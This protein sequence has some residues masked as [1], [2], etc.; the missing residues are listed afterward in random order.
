MFKLKPKTVLSH[1]VCVLIGEYTRKCTTRVN[2]TPLQL[3]GRSTMGLVSLGPNPEVPFF[4]NVS[5][6]IPLVLVACYNC[7][8]TSYIRMLFGFG[9]AKR[10]RMATAKIIYCLLNQEKGF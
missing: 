1:C 9:K 4:L 7:I 10:G 6:M 3:M 8:Q 5:A 2:A